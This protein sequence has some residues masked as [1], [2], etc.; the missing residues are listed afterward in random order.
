MVSSFERDFDDIAIYYKLTKET[1]DLDDVTWNDLEMDRVFEKV[2]S[3]K[4]YVGEQVL[5]RRLHKT[6]SKEELDQMES[7]IRYLKENEKERRQIES[8]LAKIG[9]RQSDYSLPAFLFSSEDFQLNRI[10]PIRILQLLLVVSFVSGVFFDNIYSIMV[11]IA[12]ALINLI[13]YMLHKTKYEAWLYSLMSTKQIVL[14]GKSMMSNPQFHEKL[15]AGKLERA[16]KELNGLVRMVGLF[17]LKKSGMWTGEIMALMQDYLLGITLWDMVTFQRITKTIAGK[18]DLVLEL[19]EYAGQLDMEL[20]VIRFRESLPV[21]CEPSFIGKS[22]RDMTE[23]QTTYGRN[24]LEMTG[25]YHPLVENPVENDLIMSKN[26]ILTGS[27]ASGKSTFLKAAAVNMI[28]AQSIHTCA[29]V[30]AVIPRMKVMTSMTVRDDVM[31]GESY[32]ITELKHL[33]RILDEVKANGNVF[34]IVD[35]ILRGTNT[36]E[37]LEA[38]EIVL[39]Y[40]NTKN[41][42]VLAATHDLE[43]AKAMQN[44]WRCMFFSNYVEN[45]KVM[46][47]YRLRDGFS[48]TT[49]AVLLLRTMV[50]YIFVDHS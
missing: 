36:K 18:L 45:G 50:P 2:N 9:K 11:F 14:F 26:V 40:L 12:V 29:A 41:C 15:G 48:E 31:T 17:Q 21:W 35:E 28:L 13:I 3:T 23:K 38:A 47:D 34:C 39:R 20:A 24:R 30:D 16:V 22:G 6:G 46:F 27:N 5:Y 10:W 8:D 33:K 32:Y 25:M 37:R 49:N 42:I 4:S 1:G 7:H 19:Y 43:L 44:S